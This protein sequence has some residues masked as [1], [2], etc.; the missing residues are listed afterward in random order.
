MCVFC[1]ANDGWPVCWSTQEGPI[2]F[3][4][5]QLRGRP[6]EI[7]STELASYMSSSLNCIHIQVYQ[8]CRL[9]AQAT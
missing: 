6:S 1:S 8:V 9:L 7:K 3:T 5:Q 4:L 2:R